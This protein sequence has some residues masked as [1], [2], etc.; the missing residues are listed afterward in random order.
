ME[1]KKYLLRE[2]YALCEGGVCEDLLTEDQ[3]IDVKENNA[4]YLTG[5]IQRADELNG[6]GRVYPKKVLM[7]EMK[8]YQKL[9]DENRALGECDH[10]ETSVVELKNVSHMLVESW[11]K[12]GDVMGKIKLL[13]TPMGKLLRSL[14]ESGVQLGISSRGL[15]SVKEENGKTIVEDDYQIVCYDVVS[16]PS[17]SGA[18]MSL[19]ENRT[20]TNKVFSRADRINRKL[21]AILEQE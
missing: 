13:E 2:Y 1:K 16:D 6:N 19:T 7:R 17:T 12:E 18:F 21:N 9:M 11:W 20:P 15:G 14:V 5:V 10:P 4:M 3:K 8:N